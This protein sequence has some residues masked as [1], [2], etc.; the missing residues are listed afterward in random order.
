MGLPPFSPY[1]DLTVR[2]VKRA[3]TELF[4]VTLEDDAALL[5]AHTRAGQFVRTR[6]DDE[7]GGAEAIFALASAPT[8]RRID[9][10]LRVG[11]GTDLA[12]RI[13][14]R[15]RGATLPTTLPAGEGFPIERLAGKN[16]RLVATGS[17]LAPIRSLL[18]T[19]LARADRQ[20]GTISLDIGVRSHSHLPFLEDLARWERAGVEL[21]VHLST[22]DIDGVLR[23]VRAQD[24]L[25]DRPGVSLAQDGFVV[26]G[27]FSLIG[28]LR[29]RVLAAGG[30]PENVIKNF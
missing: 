29:A 8:E 5:D 14:V 17:A 15:G 10:L 3:A 13:V 9:M 23:G 20:H 28:E 18:D 11:D 27:Q 1:R 26:A 25:L 6:L 21:A 2:S 19:L 7:S 12:S 30:D 22:V 24:A 16:L 4:L